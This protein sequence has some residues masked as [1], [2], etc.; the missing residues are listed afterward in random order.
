MAHADMLMHNALM[1]MVGDQNIAGYLAVNDPKALEQAIEA[2]RTFNEEH[3]P[4][5]EPQWVVDLY[6]PFTCVPEGAESDTEAEY[7]ARAT[8]VAEGLYEKLLEALEGTV[9]SRSDS[10]WRTEVGC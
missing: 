10:A 3:A 4:E 5:P 7:M 2:L 8:F 6:I 9:F 1:V